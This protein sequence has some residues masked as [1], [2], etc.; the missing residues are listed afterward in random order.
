[1]ICQR[2]GRLLDRDASAAIVIQKRSGD[3]VGRFAVAG[4]HFL[5]LAEGGLH[6]KLRPKSQQKARKYN[7]HRPVVIIHQ[8]SPFIRQ[9]GT[10]VL[11]ISIHHFARISTRQR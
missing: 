1:M 8:N 11:I 3:R 4:Q 7:E 5:I 10:F 2:P 6:L 9:R